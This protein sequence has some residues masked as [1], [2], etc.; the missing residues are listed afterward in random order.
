MITVDFVQDTDNTVG[1]A[2][3]QDVTIQ[4]I[5][6]LKDVQS[7]LKLFPKN[8]TH[9]PVHNALRLRSAGSGSIL[10]SAYDANSSA[11]CS[12]TVY[13]PASIND[14]FDC[15]IFFDE[16]FRECLRGIKL[17]NTR[18]DNDFIRLSITQEPMK[19]KRDSYKVQFERVVPFDRLVHGKYEPM[20]ECSFPAFDDGDVPIDWLTF[21]NWALFGSG[22]DNTKYPTLDIR[23]SR[24]SIYVDNIDALRPLCS[25]EVYRPS[26]QGIKI[27]KNY[28]VATDGYKMLTIKHM[29]HPSYLHDIEFILPIHDKMKFDGDEYELSVGIRGGSTERKGFILR[30]YEPGF[31][32]SGNLMHCVAGNTID[33]KYPNYVNVVPQEREFVAEVNIEQLLNL[34]NQQV[35]LMP[36]KV[37]KQTRLTFHHNG[38]MSVNT[39]TVDDTDTNGSATSL[40][41]CREYHFQEHSLSDYTIGINPDYL[42]SVLDSLL[43][44]FPDTTQSKAI[45]IYF[46]TPNNAMI[47][48]PKEAGS[49][50][51]APYLPEEGECM[52]C[53]NETQTLALLM[54]IR[55]N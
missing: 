12:H 52:L 31:S 25:K 44:R 2:L 27:D 17:T 10:L 46:G 9:L 30:N 47:M 7:A 39:L 3:D 22:A 54:P 15:D 1:N 51:V 26:M 6:R 34:V 48:V 43:L 36:K 24:M 4:F 55:I 8:K 33:E 38:K 16:S 40:L 14:L 35:S 21:D 5:V 28:M 41:D 19:D 50:F 11:D 37:A 42:T 18:K 49:A 53:N 45:H 32:P 29:L 20:F 13:I 23:L